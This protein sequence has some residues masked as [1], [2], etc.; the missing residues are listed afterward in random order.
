MRYDCDR[1]CNLYI[2]SFLVYVYGLRN[3]FVY[4]KNLFMTG[5][6]YASYF[7]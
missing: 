7:V 6:I 5:F 1:E 4:V 2:N 3:N